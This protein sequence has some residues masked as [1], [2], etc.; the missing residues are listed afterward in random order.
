MGCEVAGSN[1]SLSPS[2]TPSPGS[3][4]SP[5]FNPS[6]GEH[7]L[8]LSLSCSRLMQRVRHQRD[9]QG[10]SAATEW[11]PTAMMLGRWRFK[12]ISIIK[13]SGLPF[14]VTD[15]DWLVVFKN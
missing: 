3:N 14:R 8:V 9:C 13:Q 6:P 12:P 7:Q 15:S 11:T 4:A 5:G 1:P 2:P 10:I